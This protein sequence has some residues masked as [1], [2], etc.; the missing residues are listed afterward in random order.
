MVTKKIMLLVEK[1]FCDVCGAMNDD[2]TLQKC[3]V[4]GKQI[5]KDCVITINPLS[6]QPLCV[7]PGCMCQEFS[8]LIRIRD[9]ANKLEEAMHALHLKE[10]RLVDKLRNKR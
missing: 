8:E 3:Q 7:C 9:E 1:D 6:Y 5:C 2:K 10:I 4:C